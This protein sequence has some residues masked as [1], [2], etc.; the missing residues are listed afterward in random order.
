MP[1]QVGFGTKP[2]LG[3][4]M[5]ERARTV[6]LAFAWIAGDGVYGAD[7]ALRRWAQAHGIGYVPAVTTGQRLA[8]RP[9]AE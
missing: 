5:L 7:T 1:D 3:I 4:A 2:A 9:V 6:G 8:L